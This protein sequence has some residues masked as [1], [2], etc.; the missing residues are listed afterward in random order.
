MSAISDGTRNTVRW[1][2]QRLTLVHLYTREPV[3]VVTDDGWSSENDTYGTPEP[4]NACRFIPTTLLTVTPEGR[5]IATAPAASGSALTQATLT[6][7]HDDPLKEGD[8]ISDVTDSDGAVLLAGPARV[9]AIL[10]QAGLGPTV[11]KLAA[12]RGDSV[13]RSG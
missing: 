8:R 13:E 11:L 10:A 1:H 12:L 7:P 2:M 4:G 3:V 5:V 9:E 6:V